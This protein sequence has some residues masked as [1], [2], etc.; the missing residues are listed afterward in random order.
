MQTDLIFPKGFIF[1]AA[2][3]SFQIEGD[4]AGRG[5][6][7]W[8]DFCETEGNILDGSNGDVACDHVNRFKEDVAIMK[9]MGLD[10]YR[11]SVSWPRLFPD[12]SGKPSESGARF[13]NDLI[14][15]LLA[16]G[17]EPF[18]TL[19]HWD[20]PNWVYHK[21]GWLS[22]ETPILFGEYA[23]F[24]GQ[25]YGD[26]VKHYIT[27]NEPQS[28]LPAGHYSGRHAPGLKLNVKEWFRASHNFFLAHGYAVKAL[29]ETVKEA[30]IGITM[31]TDAD[32]PLTD[33]SEDVKAA[34]KSILSI[35]ENYYWHMS[36]RYW[37]DPIYLGEYPKELYERFGDKMPVM[38]PKDKE[39]ISQ[40]LDFHAQNCYSASAIQSDGA[41]GFKIAKAP[42]G[43]MKNSLNWSVTP[44]AIWFVVK[45]LWE[46]Y[47]LPIY[48]TENG[49]CCNDWI[50]E[51]GAVH[52]SYRI[53]FY[54]KYLKNL[55]RAI[56]EGADVRGFF[57]WSF[58]D[59]FEWTKGYSERFGLVY[60]DYATQK[61]TLKDSAKF[62]AE[63]IETNK[64]Q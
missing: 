24:V 32:F 7:I 22:D 26:R 35:K 42:L 29:R 14:D 51:D 6:C 44:R 52:D 3:A 39:I 15:E 55:N 27:F 28:F 10:A 21:G 54:K 9:K 59:N 5:D 13:Y 63:L 31:S 49:I 57:A 36:L 18:I 37:C 33:S 58:L 25:T 20:M 46:R 40:P 56:K 41:G 50:C 43:K 60:V 45:T 38:T 30:K 61:R 1:G 8:D 19:F 16:S 23:R 53:D 34:T 11:F 48:I 62:Y 12:Q 64:N 2:T 17:I 4:R 47:K